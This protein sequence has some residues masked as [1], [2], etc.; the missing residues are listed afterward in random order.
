MERIPD[1]SPPVRVVVMRYSNQIVDN[2]VRLTTFT[3]NFVDI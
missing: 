3:L 1:V 2:K